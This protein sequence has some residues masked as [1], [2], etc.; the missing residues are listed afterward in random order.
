MHQALREAPA[1]EAG[2][3]SHPRTVE[4]MVALLDV[5]SVS[6]SA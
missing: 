5:E 3:A 4:E 6:G 1:M 2:I